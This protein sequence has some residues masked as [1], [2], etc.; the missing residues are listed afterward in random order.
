MKQKFYTSLILLSILCISVLIMFA[1]SFTSKGISRVSIDK[2]I[3]LPLILDDEKDIKLL[4]F[5]YAGCVNV[6]TPRL[7]SL[8]TFYQ[9]LDE[10]TKQRVGIEFLDISN[11]ENSAL[12][13][14]F[15]R[16]FHKDFKGIYLDPL[17]IRE[18]TKA[19]KVY[20]SQNL[21]DETEFD[22]SSNLYLL[23]KDKDQK[24]LRYIYTSFPFDF[25][26][27]KLDIEELLYE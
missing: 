9:S 11:P 10:K 12:P 23:K 26:Q 6:C 5:G 22:H 25:K 17:V 20:F 7:Q 18:Y 24:I 3:N 21:F 16:Y 15:A 13:N 14:E 8:A 27:I 2:E 19:F 1:P 4:F